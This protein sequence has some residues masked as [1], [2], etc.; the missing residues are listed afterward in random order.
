MKNIK[1]DLAGKPQ[2]QQIGAVIMTALWCP[3]V[4]RAIET[5]VVEYLND[6]NS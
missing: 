4:V 5:G 1:I 3:S 2:Y 6:I